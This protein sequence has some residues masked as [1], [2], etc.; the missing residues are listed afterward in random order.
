MEVYNI[1]SDRQTGW[2][3]KTEW[4]IGWKIPSLLIDWVMY[5]AA[6]VAGVPQAW[7]DTSF[8]WIGV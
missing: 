7:L 8:F 6:K 4:I 3:G 1:V 5:L 2:H